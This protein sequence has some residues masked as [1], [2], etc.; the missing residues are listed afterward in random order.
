MRR[1]K[2]DPSLTDDRRTVLLA[3]AQRG[4]TVYDLARATRC[5]VAALRPWLAGTGAISQAD[6]ER[7]MAAITQESPGEQP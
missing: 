1:R 3:L 5:P 6:R 7:I 4:W 2:V